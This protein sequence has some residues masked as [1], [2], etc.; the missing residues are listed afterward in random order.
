MRSEDGGDG[1]DAS[2]VCVVAAADGRGRGGNEGR[3]V[4][5]WTKLLGTFNLERGHF[6]FPLSARPSRMAMVVVASLF[7]NRGVVAEDIAERPWRGRG[8]VTEWL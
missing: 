2:M 7:G 5:S 3:G 8:R 1:V 6:E 4:S